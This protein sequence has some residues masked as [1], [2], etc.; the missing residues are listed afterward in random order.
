MLLVTATPVLAEAGCYKDVVLYASADS[1]QTDGAEIAAASDDP[2]RQKP[3]GRRWS[4]HL[5]HSTHFGA[6]LDSNG[7]DCCSFD[8]TRL[9]FTSAAADRLPAAFIEVSP[10]PPKPT[11]LAAI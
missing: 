11:R 4:C 3:V 2:D 6:T 5:H 10:R 9:K 7:Y 8:P 1:M